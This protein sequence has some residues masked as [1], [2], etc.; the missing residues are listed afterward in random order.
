MMVSIDC[1]VW[2][3]DVFEE[4]ELCVVGLGGVFWWVYFEVGEL[5]E[6]YFED[7]EKVVFDEFFDFVMGVV[8]F[9]VDGYYNWELWFFGN[10]VEV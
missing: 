3:G 9:L 2:C 8:L 10:W 7:F 6:F 4:Y 1:V 5:I